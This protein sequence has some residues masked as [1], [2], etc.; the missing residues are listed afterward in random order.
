MSS[1]MNE[2]NRKLMPLILKCVAAAALAALL[3]LLPFG[4]SRSNQT[5]MT[6][7]FIFAV[8]GMS[9]DILKGY[10]GFLSIGHALFFGGGMYIT[11]ILFKAMGATFQALA[12]AVPAVVVF[13][14]I[15]GYLMGRLS[16]RSAGL[17]A[18][19]IT[20]ALSEIVRNAAERWRAVTGG[21]DGLTFMVPRELMDRV[22]LYFIAL[23]FMVLMFFLLNKFVRS[24][25]GRVLQS[26]RE[27]EQ[28]SI[29]LGYK[30]MNYK[31]IAMQ[32]SGITA[33]LAGVLS[34]LSTRYVNTDNLGIATTMHPLLYTLLGGEGTLIGPVIGSFVVN[35]FQTSLLSLKSVSPIF[36]KWPIFFGSL[37]VVVVL[38]MPEGVTGI[39][40]RVQV[41]IQSRRAARQRE[42]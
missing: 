28:R 35:L 33:A 21:A 31:L 12:L 41:L 19:M 25:V 17:V 34:A 37:Y 11:G 4:L 32:V 7:I 29:F 30:T 9:Y 24:P 8:Y 5:L 38:F 16:F 36:E 10:T 27:N 40:H 26:I 22:T 1:F 39:Y 15:C 2:S 42:R 18:T 3:I 23:G 14:S 6:R 20:L 13:A